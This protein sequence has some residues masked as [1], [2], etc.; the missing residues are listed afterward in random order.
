MGKR[1]D[2]TPWC[3]ML[4]PWC[5]M[6]LIGGAVGTNRYENIR[7]VLGTLGVSS[8]PVKT[9][10]HHFHIKM[11]PPT[12]RQLPQNLMA[13]TLNEEYTMF[14]LASTPESSIYLAAAGRITPPALVAPAPNWLSKT[15]DL[16][17]SLVEDLKLN[18]KSGGDVS[19]WSGY[20]YS[21]KG[22][23]GI[24]ALAWEAESEY[25][26][27][28]NFTSELSLATGSC[29]RLDIIAKQAGAWGPDCKIT[30]LIEQPKL[31]KLSPAT[32]PNA[33]AG[34][35]LYTA[36]SLGNDRVRFILENGAGKKVDVT[37]KIRIVEWVPEGDSAI[38]SNMHVAALEPAT[39]LLESGSGESYYFGLPGV[40][41]SFTNLYGGALGQTTGTTITLD[42]NAAGW[43]WFVDATPGLNEEFLP[44]AD[45]TVWIAKAG[46]AAEGKM[47]MLSVLLHEYGHTLGL[48]HSADGHSYMATTLQ[49]GMRRTLSA[50][51]QL[52]LMQLTDYFPT[53]TS[54]TD[55]FSP[56]L[57]TPLLLGLGRLRGTVTDLFT[58]SDN[59]GEANTRARLP[60]Y[61]VV[62]NPT[63]TNPAFAGNTGWSTT[64]TVAFA[65]SAALLTESATAQTRLNQL[66]VVGA[67][68]RTLRFTLADIALDDVNNAPDDAFEVAL[69]D[70]NSGLSLLGGT[71]LSRSDALLN[72]QA[73]GTERAA[74]QVTRSLN[75][76][77]SRTYLVDLTGIAAG[78]VASLSFD[79]IGFGRGAAA[80]SSH[81]TVRDLSIGIGVPQ[82][83]DDAATTAEDTPVNIAVLAN[84]L[85]A[86]QSGFAPVV[87]TG[88]THGQVVLNADGSFGY[89]PDQ[90]WYGDDSFT[91]KLSSNGVDSNVAT[92]LITVT[93]VNDAPVASAN[94]PL[95]AQED[96]A[97]LIDLLAQASD[98]DSGTNS[99]YLRSAN[100]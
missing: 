17:K 1:Q 13:N 82:T 60:Q 15:P 6:V 41:I 20:T 47:D 50:D 92:V 76:D 54:P 22:L 85:D 84:D 37:V 5:Y 25:G 33:R 86:G 67:N 19:G 57:G 87:V 79:L 72:L 27:N 4:T 18:N 59:A 34:D 29:A 62:A 11:Q 21:E 53:P 31:G 56:F 10:H 48:D 91:Y 81:I 36:Q 35:Y 80:T 24:P 66:F 51:D 93:P 45:P 30:K 68:D 44:T 100:G 95:A 39:G 70:A 64:G 99:S 74:A 58:T 65:N 77:G 71:G 16:L 96:T 83:H 3:Y 12:A 55:P 38:E 40:S 69:I 28:R 73:D 94:T 78:T 89:T 26:R 75:G 2:L 61:E 88:P 32:W 97:T 52:A 43:G 98:V 49:P 63:L 23:L 8:K 90:D 9:H 42:D 14:D 7:N 46:S